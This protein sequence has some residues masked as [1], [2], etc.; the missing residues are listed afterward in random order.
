MNRGPIRT[1]GFIG[2]ALVVAMLPWE[3][4][5]GQSQ[6]QSSSAQSVELPS[7]VAAGLLIK[8]VRPDYPKKARK[9]RIQGTVI[10]TATIRKE[11]DITDL[12][13]V[14]GDSLLAEA[15]FAA[16]KQW[17]YRPYLV[18]G[19]PVAVKTQVQVNFVLTP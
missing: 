13:L 16:V 9:R 3:P 10:M 12:T 8:K 14:S 2:V 15:A 4:V 6:D 5:Q 19:Q 7:G 17:K 11:G 1:F 18:N